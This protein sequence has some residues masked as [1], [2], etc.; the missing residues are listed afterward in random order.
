MLLQIIQK[1]I[2]AIQRIYII[3]QYARNKIKKI[4]VEKISAT[5]FKAQEI[6]I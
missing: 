4:Q 5:Y 2:I 1:T 6:S 3:P